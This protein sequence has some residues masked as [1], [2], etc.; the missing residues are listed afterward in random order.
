MTGLRLL[1]GRLERRHV[2]VAADE[3]RETAASRHVEA[4]PRRARAGQT[5]DPYRRADALDGEL[6]Q[7][8]ELEVATDEC[9]RRVAE[10]AGVGRGQGL[11]ALG[12]P[13]GVALR[14]VVHAE[15][16]ADPADDHFAGVDA[17]ARREAEA[18]GSFD[19]GH[20]TG[21]HV[22]QVQRR[23]ARALRVV[24]VRDRRPEK[25]HDAVAG[26]LVDEAFKALDALGEDGEEALNDL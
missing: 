8:F 9:R 24:F 22:A 4:R 6:A 15:I 10:V 3:A 14:R 18:V 5:V 17:H 21:E 16:V 1:Q 7:I 26:E 2:G 20:V 19:L 13:H 23:V 11:H 12:E 25:R